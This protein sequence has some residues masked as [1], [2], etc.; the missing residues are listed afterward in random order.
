MSQRLWLSRERGCLCGFVLCSYA[1]DVGLLGPA[2]QE[3]YRI[4]DSEFTRD[5]FCLELSQG[6]GWFRP[7]AS[8]LG[9]LNAMNNATPNAQLDLHED[10]E[11]HCRLTRPEFEFCN[12]Y[13]K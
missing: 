10:E 12:M 1:F 7:Y 4:E 5:L 13:Y 6:G 2:G 11:S 3:D 9:F 8:R